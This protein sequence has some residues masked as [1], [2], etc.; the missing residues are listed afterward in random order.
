MTPYH[1]LD[2]LKSDSCEISFYLA[3]GNWKNIEMVKNHKCD[4][5]GKSFTQ[6]GV[7]YR[8]ILS[9]SKTSQM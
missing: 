8:H 6:S 7:F 3:Q 4:S 9:M 5:C 1:V 2:G